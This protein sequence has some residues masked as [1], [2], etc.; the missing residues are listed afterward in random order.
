MGTHHTMSK[1]TTLGYGNG[2]CQA[3]P[4]FFLSEI[5]RRAIMRVHMQHMGKVGIGTHQTMS[6]T[7]TLGYEYGESQ[8]TPLFFSFRNHPES[9]NACPHATPGWGK[10]EQGLIR[11]RAKLPFWTTKIENS[12]RN[13]HFLLCEIFQ[14]SIMPVHMQHMNRESG[15]GDSS[16][17]EQNYQLGL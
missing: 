12:K 11:Q 7:T 3:K 15:N 9:H 8:A 13:R 10:W 14:R 17:N 6:K 4:L 16:D 1:T 2:E 5:F